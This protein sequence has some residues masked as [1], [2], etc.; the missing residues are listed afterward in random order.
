MKDPLKTIMFIASIVLAVVT[1]GA[2]IPFLAAWYVAFAAGVLATIAIGFNI[3][4]LQTA[5]TWGAFVLSAYNIMF[6][7]RTLVMQW[8]TLFQFD[9]ATLAWLENL[10]FLA[11]VAF[12]AIEGFFTIAMFNTVHDGVTLIQG[13][14]DALG[15]I[16][17]TTGTVVAGV[18]GAV[19]STVGGILG[20]T[21]GGLLSGLTSSNGF[22]LIALGVGAYFLLRKK[23]DSTPSDKEIRPYGPIPA[24]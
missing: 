6:S 19:G 9:A 20:A 7:W 2:A 14:E 4:W 11:R 15:D 16:I 18:A 21:V 23:D 12:V 8:N 5:L 3:G 24:G 13:A 17:S 10:S 1:A 22:L